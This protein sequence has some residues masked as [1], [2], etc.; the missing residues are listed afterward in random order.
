MR[1]ITIAVQ[2]PDHVPKGSQFKCRVFVPQPGTAWKLD[3]YGNH[4]V[5]EID[6]ETAKKA[7]YDYATMHFDGRDMAIFKIDDEEY[8][9]P[10]EDDPRATE[11]RLG[12]KRKKRRVV[13]PR[14]EAPG[15]APKAISW[16]NDAPEPKETA[17]E[18]RKAKLESLALETGGGRKRK[19]LAA[20][21]SKRRARGPLEL[22]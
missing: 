22:L 4:T 17:Q 8:L 9:Q 2:K 3:V 14:K 21:R 7:K 5:V 6:E 13:A 11:D 1:K 19:V 18:R 20:R 16:E 12:S 15:V 10:T